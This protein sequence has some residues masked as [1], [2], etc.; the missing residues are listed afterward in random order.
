MKRIVPLAILALLGYLAYTQGLPRLGGNDTDT[1]D[2]APSRCVHVAEVASD[3]FGN[4]VGRLYVPG[5]DRDA[6][7]DFVGAVGSRIADARSQCRCP[8]AACDKATEALEVL[9][10]LASRLD[11]NFT[12]GGAPQNPTGQLER[13]HSLLSQARGL[14]R[15]GR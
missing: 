14:T 4:D 10:G 13:V 8:A 3:T 12:S 15:E 5:G 7:A 6:W 2:D 11:D 1:G 9:D